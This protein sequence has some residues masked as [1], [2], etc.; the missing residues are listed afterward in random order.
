LPNQIARCERLDRPPH[1]GSYLRFPET[2]GRRFMIFCDTEEEFDWGKP[3]DRNARA[4]THMKTL[5]EAQRHMSAFGAKPVYLVD[6]PIAT[7]PRSIELLRPWQDAGECAVGTQL[8]PWVNPPFD[9]EVNRTNSFA[10]NLPLE[11]ERAKLTNLTETIEQAFG[12]RPIIYRAGRYGVGPNTASLLRELGYRIETSV[13]A[14]FDY[15]N[16][17]GPN[18]SRV[19]PLPYRIEGNLIE[20]PLTAAYLGPLRGMGGP[21]FRFTSGLPPARGALARSRLL[22]RV[23]LTPEGTP[24][25]EALA[26]VE[27]LL[28]DDVQLISMS[29]H[30]PSVVPGHTPFVRTQADLKKFYSWWDGVLGLLVRRG[31]TA[32][33]L[34][35]LVTATEGAQPIRPRIAKAARLRAV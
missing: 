19:K 26:A 5:P 22:N 6:H 1:A 13:R 3:H 28:D 7:D 21:I 34:E 20:L 14:M 10:G 32:A 18:F 8:H 4:T 15:S 33:S 17:K 25:A 11:L 29:Y 30:S 27:R 31:V 23:P 12:R 2:F 16:E 35:E 24:L 9:E